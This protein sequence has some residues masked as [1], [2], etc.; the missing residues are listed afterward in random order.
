MA[1][2]IGR[3]AISLG[4]ECQLHQ[5]GQ[6]TCKTTRRR[7]QRIQLIRSFQPLAQPGQKQKIQVSMQA[8][9]PGNQHHDLAIH[10][11]ATIVH[12][13]AAHCKVKNQ[14]FSFPGRQVSIIC[15][16]M[17]FAN[18]GLEFNFSQAMPEAKKF[19]LRWILGFASS[20]SPDRYEILY[21]SES[22]KAATLTISAVTAGLAGQAAPYQCL[23][24]ADAGI[25][26][27][28]HDRAKV[29]NTD[30]QSRIHAQR[31]NLAKIGSF[32]KE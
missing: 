13:G 22:S 8:L 23:H 9:P 5:S 11:H 16:R 14:F 28:S 17:T 26:F 20:S 21:S 31:R 25:F 2:Q 15:P 29:L 10:D 18:S 27:S 30:L 7:Q 6:A 3:D 1:M 24:Q 32:Q 12:I 19:A 4:L